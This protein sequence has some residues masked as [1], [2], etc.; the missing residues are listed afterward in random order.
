M[1]TVIDVADPAALP[2]KDGKIEIT[3]RAPGRR[4]FADGTRM[5]FAKASDNRRES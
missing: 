4:G 5:R 2:P 3:Y 1:S